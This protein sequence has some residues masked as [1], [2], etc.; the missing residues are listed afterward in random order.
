TED[1]VNQSFQVDNTDPT[2]TL[3]LTGTDGINGW[4]ISDVT[5]DLFNS[6]DTCSG[7]ETTYYKL[8]GSPVTS[9]YIGLIVESTEGSHV[10]EYWTVDVAGNEEAHQN[11]S[12]KIDKTAP[13]T[14]IGV[15]GTI[16]GS[17]WY[18]TDVTITLTP[19]DTHSGLNNTYWSLDGTNW[20]L[21]TNP[22][23][24]ADGTY[25][26][27]YYSSDNASLQEAENTLAIDVDTTSAVTSLA[28]L[29]G[30][31]GA[32]GWFVSDVTLNITS[33]DP[34]SGVDVMYYDLDGLGA[35]VYAPFLVVS[36]EGSHVVEYWTVDV[37]GNVEAVQNV[38]FKIDKTAPT[39]GIGVVGTMG[40]GGWY[41]TDVTV[42]LTPWDVYSD[43]DNTY[44]SLDG[45]IWTLY[46]E[47]FVL[48]DGAHTLH[49]YS[50]DNAGLDETPNTIP[51]DIDT[52]PPTSTIGPLVGTENNGWYTSSVIAPIASTDPLSGEDI[53]YYKIDGSAVAEYTAPLVIHGNGTHEIQCW[54]V[55]VAGNVEP[56][57]ALEFK[58]DML[59]PSSSVFLSGTLSASGWYTSDVT[60]SFTANDLHS[61]MEKIEYDLNGTWTTYQN[62]FVISTEGENITFYYRSL[63]AAGNVES[64]N[65]VVLSIDKTQPATAFAI[66]T[67]TMGGGGWY[68][69]VVTFALTPSDNINLDSTWYIVDGGPWEE[70][71]A[72]VTVTGTDE[73]TIW[74]RSTDKAGNMEPIRIEIISIDT[75][76][77]ICTLDISG[78]MGQNGWY[79]SEATVTVVASDQAEGSGI[80][81]RWYRVDGGIWIIYSSP[82][83]IDHGSHVFDA[84]AVDV[85]NNVGFMASMVVNVD[86]NTPSTQLIPAGIV[87]ENGWYLSN[88]TMT[89]NGTEPDPLGS[90]IQATHYTLDGIGSVYA[91]PFDITGVGTHTLRYWSEDAAGNVEDVTTTNVRIDYELPP[92]TQN[93]IGT[94]Q[95]NGWYKYNT[96]VE[97]K[98]GSA[99]VGSGL[100]RF[101]YTTDGANWTT[102]PG[103]PVTVG[104]EGYHNISSRAVDTAGNIGPVQT[105]MM[106]ID[107]Y[108]PTGSST[109][110]AVG[111]S[112]GW[113]QGSVTLVL[114]GEDTASPTSIEY[115]VNGGA[116]MPY[117][118]P[119]VF[120]VDG[121]YNVTY[122]ATD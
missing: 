63:D 8:D 40:G 113:C 95:A 87:G 14:G 42:T 101:E 67:G 73:H 103:T 120:T 51:L 34:L 38:S 116:W 119:L 32:G 117:M 104:G 90:G 17:G 85:A 10:V 61:G 24:L 80:K 33:L 7:S 11:A 58:I 45:V 112:N 57:Q 115:S 114:N 94:A 66:Q 9:Q 88:V 31:P 77:P 1:V 19:S 49:Y 74:Y 15:V 28:P 29:S 12:F 6:T 106:K 72:P 108:G 97:I 89:L 39:T 44:W 86:L 56:M 84:W 43:F 47:P 48:G 46:A 75:E 78:S 81:E 109:V 121:T 92:I 41:R 82:V 26:V 62:P 13:H 99:D 4:F 68:D 21:Y 23:T 71:A 79:V 35:A 64:N 25:S 111:G 30:T 59:A 55:D 118:P 16:G 122:R 3:V 98:T 50:S 102:Y 107:L 20:T 22:F 2:T 60:I 27:R 65:T 69:S 105:T 52:T 93:I 70:Y 91:G 53:T 100:A 54:T 83:V 36:T 76:A 96:S 110:I 37:A 18:R 5:V